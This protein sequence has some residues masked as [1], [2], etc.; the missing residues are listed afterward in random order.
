MI[1]VD[2]RASAALRAAAGANYGGSQRG[3]VAAAAVVGSQRRGAQSVCKRATSRQRVRE[4]VCVVPGHL[5]RPG[6]RCEH[7]SLRTVAGNDMGCV[8][9]YFRKGSYDVYEA[10]S[11]GLS[12]SSTQGSDK[13]PL[14]GNSTDED[15]LLDKDLVIVDANEVKLAQQQD[16]EAE[17]KPEA[18]R[19]KSGASDSAAKPVVAEKTD[20]TKSNV[21]SAGAKSPARS[22]ER[23][24]DVITA[25]PAPTP[26]PA[27]E[28]EGEGGPR[29]AR[30]PSSSTSNVS[31]S[32]ATGAAAVQPIASFPETPEPA[33]ADKAAASKA[34]EFPAKAVISPTGVA[35]EVKRERPASSEKSPVGSPVTASVEVKQES[36]PASPT[37]PPEA[38][39]TTKTDSPSG[40][41][42]PV[43]P[44]SDEDA[45]TAQQE[46]KQESEPPQSPSVKSPELAAEVASESP[47]VKAEE[48]PESPTTDE[49]M[50]PSKSDTPSSDVTE[51]KV[52]IPEAPAVVDKE[53]AATSAVPAPDEPTPGP[54]TAE[55]SSA[56]RPTSIHDIPSPSPETG[57][58]PTTSAVT[59]TTVL[60]TP[61][62]DGPASPTAGSPETGEIPTPTV[63]ITVSP[64]PD[65]TPTSSDDE[66]P[67]VIPTRQR[68]RKEPAE[69]PT[70]SVDQEPP[71]AAAHDSAKQPTDTESVDEVLPSSPNRGQSE[72]TTASMVES[73][74]DSRADTPHSVLATAGSELE[75][76]AVDEEVLGAA[77]AKIQAGFRGYKTRQEL[78]NGAT[79]ESQEE[80]RS[81]ELKDQPKENEA[82]EEPAVLEAAAT[83]IQATI[84]GHQTRQK[85]KE[86]GIV[87][88]KNDSVVID[89]NVDADKGTIPESLIGDEDKTA[90]E[91]AATTI[92]AT[93][94]GYQTRQQV[95]QEKLQE[96]AKDEQIPGEAVSTDQVAKDQQPVT[97]EVNEAVLLDS[98]PSALESAA[99]TIQATF[100]GYKTRQELEKEGKTEATEES[101]KA[102]AVVQEKIEM[103]EKKPEVK[104]L[105]EK[106]ET[107][108]PDSKEETV[109]AK[110]TNL[111][112]GGEKTDIEAEKD[113]KDVKVD[114]ASVIESAATT[115]QAAFKGYQTRQQLKKEELI[116]AAKD[117]ADDAAAA[118]VSKAGD[119]VRDAESPVLESAATTIQAAFRGH[120]TRKQLKNKGDV[121]SK[122]ESSAQV[123]DEVSTARAPEVS[124]AT[125]EAA[126]HA[127]AASIQATFRGYKTRQQLK[128]EGAGGEPGEAT[129]EQ[130]SIEQQLAEACQEAGASTA[131]ADL[132]A[133][134][135]TIQANFRGF[136]TRKEFQQSQASNS[137][138]GEAAVQ[139]PP[140]PPQEGAAYHERVLD[141]AAT[142]IQATFRGYQT[143]QKVAK[144]GDKPETAADA[145]QAVPQSDAAPEEACVPPLEDMLKTAPAGGAAPLETAAS[146]SRASTLEASVP[147]VEDTVAAAATA[148]R[149][150]ALGA[151]P[152][153]ASVPPPE[154]AL[155]PQPQPPLG[156]QASLAESLHEAAVPPLEDLLE[157]SAP[158]QARPPASFSSHVS[159]ADNV[160]DTDTA[161]VPDS[162]QKPAANVA[163]EMAAEISAESE[164]TTEATPRP[165]SSGGADEAEAGPSR[166]VEPENSAPSEEPDSQTDG[167]KRDAKVE[168]SETE[169]KPNE[170]TA[171]LAPQPT[172]SAVSDSADRTEPSSSDGTVQEATT[173][174]EASAN[175]VP[176]LVAQAEKEVS[177]LAIASVEA[178][179]A[180]SDV[181][182]PE[183]DSK[184]E[185]SVAAGSSEKG[186]VGQG[187]NASEAGNE[188]VKEVEEEVKD[189]N[190]TRKEELKTEVPVVSAR[191]EPVVDK[192]SNETEKGGDGSEK[193]HAEPTPSEAVP[194]VKPPSPKEA[195]APSSAEP[196]L[197]DALQPKAA[198]EVT[199]LVVAE[200]ATSHVGEISKDETGSVESLPE[201]PTAPLSPKERSSPPS[202]AG[203][204]LS[205]DAALPSPPLSSQAS[206]SES[207]PAAA[208]APP[209]LASAA[210]STAAAAAAEDS[211]LTS[212]ATPEPPS[213]DALPPPPGQGSSRSDSEATP[214]P[215]AAE[216]EAEA[217]AETASVASASGAPAVA[218]DSQA[219]LPPPPP[220]QGAAGDSPPDSTSVG[221]GAVDGDSSLPPPPDNDNNSL[222]DVSMVTDTA[223][224]A[225]DAQIPRS[226]E[227]GEQKKRPSQMEELSALQRPQEC[228]ELQHQQRGAAPL[229]NSPDDLAELEEEE[230][231][232]SSSVD[233]A[234]TKIQAGVRGFLT[235]RHVQRMRS[236]QAPSPGAAT[237]G[238][239]AAGTMGM[240]LDSAMP[241]VASA[242]ASAATR[243]AEVLEEDGEVW[244]TLK[245][246]MDDAAS[247]IQSGFRGFQARQK[248]T[249]AEA[250]RAASSGSSGSGGGSLDQ[251]TLSPGPGSGELHDSLVLPPPPPPPQEQDKQ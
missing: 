76:S 210:A 44:V 39:E 71:S 98:D 134:A 223:S 238:T 80:K 125:D 248:L 62:A 25:A 174:K 145:K 70:T 102:K 232:S 12:P 241:K 20:E 175:I 214:V 222:T 121:D 127:A 37:T 66:E 201:P 8:Q 228:A 150:A 50:A 74:Q 209:P 90:L 203:E 161:D 63:S 79:S 226:P 197:E 148:G 177:K 13:P 114:D 92:Q 184:K 68:V 183:A 202:E 158:A 119:A 104:E 196:A 38:K 54:S 230:S 33:K 181:V 190:A 147:P 124:G 170:M 100:R 45:S 53:A 247:T 149:E 10:H 88:T 164:K 60:V 231:V 199:P 186:D 137:E 237:A 189:D 215:E 105:E 213:E 82:P 140:A 233:S 212:T 133:A 219:S 5:V 56:E 244:D 239:I 179:V 139:P 6:W 91:S 169:P 198:E 221:A 55:I 141:A 4:C 182:E 57:E 218:E 118:V 251:P 208:S 15:A 178:P 87:A 85:L 108:K 188:G 144:P 240:S 154:D 116:D 18:E 249:R 23:P 129:P 207:L 206:L 34:P 142:T 36:K 86:E 128:N 46:T 225:G 143:R 61:S 47:A 9:S 130:P 123:E 59:P 172:S 153:E 152:P 113:V 117:I 51:A 95:K 163:V 81:D 217:E 73:R 75:D 43:S 120:H 21:S 229:E 246:E 58:L 151:Q 155:P 40:E 31:L 173:R 220:P 42:K 138:T 14:I 242:A 245:K 187:Q 109:E 156:T 28:K 32:S 35:A 103:E 180:Q 132:E 167:E 99:T 29:H 136:R 7:V 135:T 243:S 78:K 106:N 159:L 216:A 224:E 227:T 26:A 236:T 112:I 19:K 165:P 16:G 65:R 250:V 146:L 107:P 160:P 192:A 162:V 166:K 3:G 22:V 17:K 96:A 83:K 49:N 41:H 89:A 195:T 126:L 157:K 211:P 84:R 69:S 168:S 77:A 200:A 11:A 171:A 24:E 30:R 176:S 97:E 93:F 193:V 194:V 235:R 115:I 67:I 48:K 110:G 234:A 191:P 94:R 64:A 101:D 72:A 111:E 204:P 52:A 2:T 185:P 205:S 1:G 122:E 131:A 27:P